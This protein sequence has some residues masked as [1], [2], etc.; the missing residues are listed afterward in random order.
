[1][2]LAAERGKKVITDER[3]EIT[4]IVASGDTLAVET[5]WTGVLQIP[6]DSLPI[7]GIVRARFA[8]FFEFKDG[9]IQRQRNY[10]CFDPF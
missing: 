7:G 10:D 5:I 6:Y 9:K 3:Y 1:M 8:V 2:K 4:N